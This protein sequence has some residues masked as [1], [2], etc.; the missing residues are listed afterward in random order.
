MFEFEYNTAITNWLNSSQ[1]LMLVSECRLKRRQIHY[2]G[3]VEPPSRS[4][5]RG[6]IMPFRER[7][8]VDCKWSIGKRI[9]GI[10]CHSQ[11]NTTTKYQMRCLY[12]IT[13]VNAFAVPFDSMRICQRNTVYVLS[14]TYI[15]AD[16]WSSFEILKFNSLYTI[17]VQSKSASFP[18]KVKL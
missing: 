12:A 15:Y 14:K 8:S 4:C 3:Y 6:W 9:V 17:C 16:W 7:T 2:P 18:F 11:G 13:C 10:W 1:M 5:A